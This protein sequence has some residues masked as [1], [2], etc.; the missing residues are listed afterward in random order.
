MSARK[1]ASR[2]DAQARFASYARPIV[3]EASERASQLDPDAEDLHKLRIALRRLR[4]LLWAWRPLLDREAAER[5]RAFLKHAGAAAGA[6]RDWD[7][8]IELLRE[9]D[10]SDAGSDEGLGARL[11]GARQEAREQAVGTLEAA[12]LKHALRDMLH[13]MNRELNTAP[14]RTSVK[15]L[16]RKRV[17]AARKTLRKR[18]RHA[19][20]AKRSDY[21]AWHAVRKGGKKLRYVLEFFGPELPRRETKRLKPL[22]KLQKRFGMLNDTVATERLLD[23]NREVFADAASADAA[24]ATLDRARKQRLRRAAKLIEA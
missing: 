13:K 14:H 24:L 23:S 4:T 1:A 12:D 20:Q 10:A 3:N 15:S 5:E 16:A 22:K 18:I 19:R 7:I 17:Q 6:A 2:D 11:Q 8:A 9:C 21:D